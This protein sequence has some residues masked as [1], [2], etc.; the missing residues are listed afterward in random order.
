M[1][2]AKFP[3]YS[4]FVPASCLIANVSKQCLWQNSG[5][6]AAGPPSPC[7]SFSFPHDLKRRSPFGRYPPVALQK[8]KKKCS[9]NQVFEGKRYSKTC[10]F[11]L[12]G[13]A[14]RARK[15][16][17]STIVLTRVCFSVWV[18]RW[19][20]SLP[21]F[22]LNSKTDAHTRPYKRMHAIINSFGV[23]YFTLW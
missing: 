3:S 2:S 23:L 19:T 6:E 1:P 9:P 16:E 11:F 7:V 12:I 18:S 21:L 4:S 13:C 8:K 14:H 5:P 17:G 15:K 22:V 10:V 20:H